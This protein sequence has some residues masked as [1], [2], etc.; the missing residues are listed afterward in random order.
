M[1]AVRGGGAVL[2]QWSIIAACIVLTKW[3][4][5]WWTYPIAMLVVATR[6]HALAILV[7]EATHY[8]LLPSRFWNDFVSDVF[9]AFPL[10]LS[11]SLYRHFHFAHH[12]WTVTDRDPE[13]IAARDSDE[14]ALP[15]VRAELFKILVRDLLGLNFTKLF[16]A[17][18]FTLLYKL[19]GR[20]ATTQRLPRFERLLAVAFTI[21]L[22]ISLWL[23]NGWLSFVFLWLVPMSTFLLGILRIRGLAE[24]AGLA[25][26]HELNV[27]RSTAANWLERLLIAP[28]HVNYHLEHHLFPSVPFYNLPKLHKR[29]MQEPAFQAEAHRTKGYLGFS[30]GV[31]GEVMRSSLP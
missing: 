15:K 2:R 3:A 31:L 16:S 4:G 30:S 26:E 25:R 18:Y 6:Q 9:C 7:H 8:R 17:Y 11:T 21:V 29:L 20:T 19:R 1:S 10:G 27:S 14:A 5:H 23:T 24:H 28:C 22:G 13:N 12:R